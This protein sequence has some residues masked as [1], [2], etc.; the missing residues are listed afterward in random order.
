MTE[1]TFVKTI[2]EN[3]GEL[4]ITGGWV[5]DMIA[6]RIPHD[7]DYVI[8][9]MNESLFSQ[10]F[11]QAKKIGKSFPVFLLHIDG[12][13]CEIAFA[14]KEKK[15][16]SGY[17]GF[18]PIYNEK[19]SIEE[20]LFRRDTR[21]NSIALKLPEKT[22]IDPF[23]G[24]TDIK[25]K[26]IHA[27]SYHFGEDPVRA[28][29]AARQAA[30]FLFTIDNYTLQQ[31]EKCA[32]ELKDE[33]GERII[34]ELTKALNTPMPSIF[35]RYL[36]KSH[37]LHIIF[38][39]IFALRGQIQPAYCHPEGDSFEHTMLVLDQ[40]AAVTSHTAA[41]FAALCHDLGKGLTPANLLPHHYG[42]EITGLAVLKAWQKRT[43]LPK[44][45]IKSAAF[46]I[47]EHMRA[48]RL[49]KPGKIVDLVNSIEKNPL[50]IDDFC[51]IIKI[52][53]KELPYYLENIHELLALFHSVDIN[54]RP[55]HIC[56]AQIAIWLRNQQIEI[57]KRFINYNLQLK[58]GEDK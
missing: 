27:T 17:K 7:K 20:D 53:N 23:S 13:N 51:Q 32:L 29:R 55:D 6:G 12:K 40:T 28:L 26:L 47:K 43:T 35:F 50:G 14:R 56:G 31:M 24:C 48:A 42:H 5:R 54:K 21:L 39:E 57:L 37:L 2:I 45:W 58:T 4:Y 41:R 52:D 25:N 46:V 11:P 38:P 34:I 36:Q 19:I 10:L 8:C 33:P 44:Q 18:I 9:K 15:V 22:L 3:N 16:G 49:S 30:Q 1:D